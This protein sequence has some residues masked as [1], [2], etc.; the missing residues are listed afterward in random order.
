MMD[1]RLRDRGPGGG[2][3]TVFLLVIFFEVISRL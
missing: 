1:Q 2:I 3:V